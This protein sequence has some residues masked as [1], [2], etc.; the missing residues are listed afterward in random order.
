VARPPQH[1]PSPPSGQTLGFASAFSGT[2]AGFGSSIDFAR[3]FQQHIY[4][5]N[6][7]YFL[8]SQVHVNLNQKN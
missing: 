5:I 7:Q 8:L 3:Y 1:P 4:L 2:P 6:P